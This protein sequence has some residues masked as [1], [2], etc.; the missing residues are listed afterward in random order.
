M[1]WWVVFNAALIAQREAA[2]SSEV[3]VYYQGFGLVKENR[4]LNLSKGRQTVAVGD[5]SSMME[6]NSVAL[7]SLSDKDSFRVL[8]QNYRYDLISPKAI[9]DKAVGSRIRFLRILPNS[10]RELLSGV[11][12]SS[13]TSVDYQGNAP[14]QVFNGMVIRTDD[15]RIVLDPVGEVEIDSIPEGMIS[16]PT[17]LWDLESQREGPDSVELSY[18]TEG[19]SWT[20]DY[21]LTLDGM[22]QADLLGWVTLNNR[23][24]ATFRNAKLNLMA[25]DV[26]LDPRRLG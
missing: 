26:H 18:V 6:P 24:G 15:G 8:E 25:G 2:P 4:T 3:T 13:P 20:A 22:G 12:L 5:V 21:G 17:L 10:K 7:K 16:K 23:G 9:L 11:L 19:M 14:N 1:I